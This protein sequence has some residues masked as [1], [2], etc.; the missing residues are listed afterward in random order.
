MIIH[1]INQ[2]IFVLLRTTN[3]KLGNRKNMFANF[4]D[5]LYARKRAATRSSFFGNKIRSFA[6]A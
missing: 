1:L 5:N 6:N 4:L 2:S 3:K